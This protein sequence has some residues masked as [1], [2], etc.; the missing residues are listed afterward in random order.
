MQAPS[1]DTF[2][3]SQWIGDAFGRAIV[4]DTLTSRRTARRRSSHKVSAMRCIISKNGGQPVSKKSIILWSWP[5]QPPAQKKPI[6]PASEACGLGSRVPAVDFSDS[7]GPERHCRSRQ[8]DSRPNRLRL[9][10][11]A[12][13][14]AQADCAWPLFCPAAVQRQSHTP[15]ASHFRDIEC[16]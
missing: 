2:L 5:E 13:S 10:A 12:T 14:L 7:A 3:T 8:V 4:A 15:A 16:P 11:Q 9:R 1:G 6:A